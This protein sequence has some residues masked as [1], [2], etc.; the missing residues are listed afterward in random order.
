MRCADLVTVVK[1]LISVVVT[2]TTCRQRRLRCMEFCPAVLG[3]TSDTTYSSSGMW[4]N[5]SCGKDF[6]V[7]TLRAVLFHRAGE[8]MAGCAGVP[9]AF[10]C[11]RRK[12]SKLRLRVRS[13]NRARCIGARVPVGGSDGK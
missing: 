1:S 10:D 6:C 7:M 3:M 5:N 9:I 13:G 2:F 4:L 11:N 12:D 8:R